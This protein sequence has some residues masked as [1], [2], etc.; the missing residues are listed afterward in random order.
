M[1]KFKL[2]NKWKTYLLTQ[3][4]T[5]MGFQVVKII[6][7]DGTEYKNVIITNADTVDGIYDS[8]MPALNEQDILQ[9]AVT[10]F[11]KDKNFDQKKWNY[12]E[13]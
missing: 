11:Q 5:G 9:L 10:H 7:K 3:P 12:F 2:P 8:T 1:K 6:T 4:E 13:E